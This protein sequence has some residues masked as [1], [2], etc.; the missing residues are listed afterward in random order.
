MVVGGARLT[1]LRGAFAGLGTVASA[2]APP[3]APSPPAPTATGLVIAAAVARCRWFRTPVAVVPG[4]ALIVAARGTGE[5]RIEGGIPIECRMHRRVR[6]DGESLRVAA[7]GLLV[8]LPR[9][10]VGPGRFATSAGV[11]VAVVASTARRRRLASFV[12]RPIGLGSAV[13]DLVVTDV[14]TRAW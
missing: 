5:G 4:I 3:S 1:L 2:T 6:F 12:A 13:T 7:A 14:A 9:P 8:G 11:G 10:G